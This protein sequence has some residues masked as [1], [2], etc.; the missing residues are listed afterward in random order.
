MIMKKNVL[1]VSVAAAL[2]GVAGTAL[3]N[4]SVEENGL[5]HALIVPY[6]STQS[7][8]ATL[9]NIVNTDTVNGKAVKVRFRSAV[10]SDDI[11]DFQVFLS[12]GDV[13]TAN[14]SSTGGASRL[15]TT[16]NSCTLPTVGSYPDFVTGRLA[17]YTDAAGT[18]HDVNEQTREG[19][20]EIFNMADIPPYLT[21]GTAALLSTAT[22]PLF[23]AIKHVNGVAPCTSATLLGIEAAHS[24]AV[25]TTPMVVAGSGSVGAAAYASGQQLTMPT[26]T[27]MGNWTII[28]VP[29]TQV[30]SGGMPAIKANA[31]TMIVYSGQVAAARTATHVAAVDSTN[32]ASSAVINTFPSLRLTEDGVLLNQAQTGVTTADYDFPDM[33]TPYEVSAGGLV[34][35][36]GQAN[37]LSTAILRSA[38]VNEYLTDSTVNAGTDW[39]LSMPTRRYH[40]AGRGT[41]YGAASDNN[42]YSSSELIDGITGGVTGPFATG[43]YVTFASNG[44]SACVATGSSPT[45]YNR[46]EQ[47]SGGS[48]AVISPGTPSKYSLCG[49]VN[50]LSWNNTGATSAVLGATLSMANSSTGSYNAGWAR[51][52]MTASGLPI[53]GDAFGRAINTNVTPAAYFGATYKHRYQ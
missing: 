25:I 28:N 4:L 20:V 30:F 51:A 27:L 44:R 1:A 38:V 31:Q 46:E 50:V 19:Y 3:A 42:G 10:D 15:T 43:S 34:T 39:V 36:F 21:A 41:N 16:D 5:G 33:S 8:N 32:A 11:Y 35:P 37:A 48:G 22:N 29:N 6:F 18:V 23:T 14:V 9:L 45:Y 17:A 12:P 26:G 40:V 24:G 47:T 7:G 52:T 49:E 53:L 13:W 2:S